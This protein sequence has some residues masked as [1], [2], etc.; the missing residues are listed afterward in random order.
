MI[1]DTQWNI[2]QKPSP[3][4]LDALL[5][6]SASYV[7]HYEMA[8][9]LSASAWADQLGYTEV[10]TLLRETLAEEEAADEKLSMLAKQKIN[11]R[12]QKEE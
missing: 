11:A 4:A 3:A 2:K 1:E 10:G 9:Y 6:S 7:E 12:A 8:G 5:I